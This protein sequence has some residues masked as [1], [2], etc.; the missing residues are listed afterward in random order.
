VETQFDRQ[1]RLSA[2]P[3]PFRRAI[4]WWNLNV[5]GRARA[6]RAGTFVLSTLAGRG[7]EIECPPAF[8]TAN[9]TY[10]PIGVDGRSRLTLA[11]DHRVFDGALAAE[12]LE[13]IEQL[14]MTNLRDELESLRQ[15][16]SRTES[17]ASTPSAASL[18]EPV[19]HPQ[20]AA[21]PR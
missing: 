13:R 12:A 16:E 10:G 21:C 15:R 6:R 9:F 11:Y 17:P 2:I 20:L 8:H 7:A 14:L 5:S 3:N 1:L 18:T 4:C 19:C